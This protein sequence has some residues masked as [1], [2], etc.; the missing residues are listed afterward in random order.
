M[1]SILLYAASCEY[2]EIRLVGGSN[3]YEG[4]VEICIN[5]QWGTVCDDD[6]GINDAQVVCSQLGIS[7]NSGTELC[8]YPGTCPSLFVTSLCGQV[9]HCFMD[10]LVKEVVPSSWTMWLALE[11]KS[12]YSPATAAKLD[13]TTVSI[14][15]MWE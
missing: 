10:T 9:R 1:I 14:R 4:R 11:Q 12:P 13:L 3:E 2:G 5:G 7:F 6:W 8:L 15:M